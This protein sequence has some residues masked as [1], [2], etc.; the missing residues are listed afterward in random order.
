LSVRWWSG[1]L[2]RDPEQRRWH[3]KPSVIVV[4][5]DRMFADAV[6][7]ALERAGYAVRDLVE[8]SEEAIV[9]VEGE[10]PEIVLVEVSPSGD[11]LSLG[12]RIAADCRHETRVVALTQAEDEQLVGRSVRMGF[13]GY[14]TRSMTTDEFVRSID[15]IAEGHIVVPRTDPAPSGSAAAGPLEVLTARERTVLT[16]LVRGATSGEIAR[17][18]SVSDN[19]VRTH[20]QNIFAKL[21]VRSRVQAAAIAVKHGMR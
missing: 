21:G 9:V 15:S 20:M 6:S 10:G 3:P 16:L 14:L 2:A 13:R 18:L 11:G 19:T 4:G 8:P 5:N 1:D 17:E 7:V 12:A